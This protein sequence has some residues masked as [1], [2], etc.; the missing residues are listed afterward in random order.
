VGVVTLVSG[1]LA[2]GFGAGVLALVVRRLLEG[3]WRAP[4]R[5][6]SEA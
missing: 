2:I 5:G 3:E 4:L 6:G 1:N